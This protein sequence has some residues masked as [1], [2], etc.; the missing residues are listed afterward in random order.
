MPVNTTKNTPDQHQDSD[1]I[2]NAQCIADIL[3]QAQQSLINVSHSP[4]LDADILLSHIL[5]CDRSLLKAWPDRIVSTEHQAQFFKLI[6]QRET[7]KPIAYL[8]GT[9]PFW[10]FD[11]DVNEH[12]LVP[13]PETELLVEQAL[14]LIDLEQKLLVA[15]VCTGSGAIAFALASERPEIK[16]HASDIDS[17]A[18]RV[19]RTTLNRL[20]L[21]NIVF[22]DGD[23]YDA[24]P[25]NNY[26]IIVSNPPY[27]DK[28][29]PYLLHPTMQHEPRHALIADNNGLAII[30]QL[31]AKSNNFLKDK[32][33]LLLEHGHEQ[34]ADIR[35]LAKE[36]GLDYLMCLQDYQALDRISVLQYKINH[37]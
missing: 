29:D 4:S 9:K 15:D 35:N 1:N 30:E 11:I 7:G 14:R 20:E 2:E 6:E 22:F 13:R 31:I 16:V 19:A 37:H 21:R 10:T 27:I 25:E 26:D 8:L 36:H 18:L 12:T 32:G 28:D 3:L 17:K 23:L 5:E 34:A 24:L 33:Y